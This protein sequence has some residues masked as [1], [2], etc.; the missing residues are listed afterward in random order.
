MPRFFALHNDGPDV[1]NRK[2]VED[3]GSHAKEQREITSY[4]SFI[5][6]AG[7]HAACVIDAPS[8]AWLEDYFKAI[9]L[10]VAALFE[11]EIETLDGETRDPGAPLCPGKVV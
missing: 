11:V 3:S 6:M 4:R 8:K 2:M 7:G 1:V 5:N 9:Q 10:P